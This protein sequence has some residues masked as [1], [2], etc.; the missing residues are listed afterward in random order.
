MN[1]K[2]EQIIELK[3]IVNRAIGSL[4]RY[5]ISLMERQANERSIAFRFGLYFNETLRASSF[6]EDPD[7]TIDFDYNRN[8]DNVKNMHGFNDTH[9]VYPDIILHHRG[10]NDKNVVVIEFKGSWNRKRR[11]RRDDFRKLIEFTHQDRNDYQYGLGVFVDLGY[12]LDGCSFTYFLN[13]EVA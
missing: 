10:F 13:G 9:G 12:D 3:T 7:L 6:A 5:D 11:A 4:Y 8:L 2:E 1:L